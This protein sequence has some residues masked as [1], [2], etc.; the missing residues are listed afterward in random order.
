M[1]RSSQLGKSFNKTAIVACRAK[2]GT[3]IHLETVS[4]LLV[5]VGTHKW[6]EKRNTVPTLL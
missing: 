1:Q 6:L 5:S 2:E 4:I 3:Q